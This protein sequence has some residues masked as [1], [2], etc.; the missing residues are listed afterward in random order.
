MQFTSIVLHGNGHYPQHEWDEASH[1]C[2]EPRCINIDHL[3]WEPLHINASRKYCHAYGQP[4]THVPQCILVPDDEKDRA[5]AQLHL[6][7]TF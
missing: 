1:L 4:C 6:P 3:R 2:G 5:Y 7:N